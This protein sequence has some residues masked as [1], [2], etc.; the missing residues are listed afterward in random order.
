MILTGHQPTYLPWLGLFN[1]IS[2]SDCFVLFDNVQYLPKEWMN[3]NKI[4]TPNGEIFLDA[5]AAIEAA[6]TVAKILAKELNKSDEWKQKE[7]VDFN[8][9]AMHYVL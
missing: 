8:M 2:N 4:K 3:R 7:I 6:P 5:R 9:V 1:K